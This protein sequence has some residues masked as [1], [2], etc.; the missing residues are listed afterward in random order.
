MWLSLV[1]WVLPNFYSDFVKAL[2]AGD[3]SYSC[4][5]FIDSLLRYTLSKNLLAKF[6]GLYQLCSN[7]KLSKAKSSSR[8]FL[9]L[10]DCHYDVSLY[11]AFMKAFYWFALKTSFPRSHIFNTLALIGPTSSGKTTILN[12]FSTVLAG[13]DRKPQ[14]RSNPY[15]SADVLTASIGVIDEAEILSQ[16]KLQSKGF[17]GLDVVKDVLGSSAN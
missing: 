4:T 7:M 3:D 16:E 12:C 6:R 2:H 1:Q 8:I 9:S 15:S 10:E 17:G 14:L 5:P 11:M 13:W